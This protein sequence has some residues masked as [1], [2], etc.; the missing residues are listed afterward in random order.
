MRTFCVIAAMLALTAPAWGRTASSNRPASGPAIAPAFYVA[1]S[2]GSDSNAGTLA[3]PFATLGKAQAAMI[4]SGTIKTAYLRTGTYL[5]G[6][7]LSLTSSDNEETWSTYPLDTA[8]SAILRRNYN[9]T[10][11]DW[12]DIDTASNITFTN[13]TI[14]GGTAPGANTNALRYVNSNG[15]HITNNHFTNNATGV[16]ITVYNSD[17][18]FIQQNVSDTNAY[19]FVSVISNDGTAHANWFITDNTSTNFS[20]DLNDFYVI[21]WANNMH[22]DRNI[23]TSPTTNTQTILISV[24]DIQS[25]ICGTIYGNTVNSLPSSGVNEN[26]AIEESG[27]TGSVITT[28][29]N[30]VFDTAIPFLIGNGSTQTYGNTTTNYGGNAAH[31]YAF[32]EDGGFVLGHE[33]VGANSLNGS[34]VT[35]WTGHTYGATP[36]FCTASTPP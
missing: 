16:D 12:L 22:V 7:Q 6:T 30:T 33:W 11:D 19:Q 2:G 15:V 31:S 23:V 29:G 18:V 32:Q 9:A 3:A 28:S 26:T 17:N 14:D 34:T 1:A 13:L 5:I 25:T 21:G 4:A 10:G 24:V 35:G 20:G 8:K 36:T 27:T